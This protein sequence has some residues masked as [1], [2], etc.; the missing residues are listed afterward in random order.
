MTER[1]R[2]TDGAKSAEGGPSTNR[3]QVPDG[4]EGSIMEP[5]SEQEK[6][7]N[8]GTRPAGSE[9]RSDEL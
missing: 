6:P 8:A 9:R 4:L 3:E 2:K 5:E 7:D 1:E